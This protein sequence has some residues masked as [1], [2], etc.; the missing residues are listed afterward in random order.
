MGQQIVSNL[1]DC[2]TTAL[3]QAIPVLVDRMNPL[4]KVKAGADI[5][6]GFLHPKKEGTESAPEGKEAISPPQTPAQ[7]NVRPQESTDPAY[8]QVIKDLMYLNTLNVILT[9]GPEGDIDWEKARGGSS[10]PDKTSSVSF[11]QTL[12][13][14]AKE[15]FATM[16][17]AKAPSKTYMSVLSVSEKVRYSFLG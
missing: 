15:S 16:A 7:Q 14:D 2:V 1:A 9:S 5:V 3:N 12:L 10:D 11:V 6:G 17:T 13:S 4:K 8:S